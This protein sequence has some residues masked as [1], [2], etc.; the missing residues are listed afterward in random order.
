MC[1]QLLSVGKIILLPIQVAYINSSFLYIA[2]Y[3][4]INVCLSIY[5]FLTITMTI[6]RSLHVHMHSFLLG[7]H[8]RVEWLGHIIC[9]RLNFWKSAKIFSQVVIAFYIFTSSIQS[10]IFHIF[11]STWYGQLIIWDILINVQ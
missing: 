4:Y 2:S 6:Y 8:L 10:Y 5:L 9:V 7:K 3:G 11:A 1:V